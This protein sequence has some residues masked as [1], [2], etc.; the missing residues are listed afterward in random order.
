MSL[1]EYSPVGFAVE[2]F[3]QRYTIHPKEVFSNACSRVGGHIASAEQN[4]KREK[5]AERF[6]KIL[7]TNRFSPGGRIWRGCGRPKGQLLNCFV[8]PAEDSREGWGDLLKNT[9]IIS[10]LGGGIGINFSHVRPRG[11]EIKGTGG[12]A[13]GAVSLMEITNAVGDV[14]REGGGRRTALMFG[15]MY[16]HPDLKEF[17]DKKLDHDEINNANISVMIDNNFLDLVESNGDVVF[18]WQGQQKGKM[19][20]HKIWKTIV[21]NAWKCGDPGVLNYGLANEMNTISYLSNLDCTNPCG[22]QFLEPYG[23]CCLGSL[24]LSTHIIDGEMDW[25]LLGD[26][27]TLAVRFLDN[28]ISINHYPIKEVE[29]QCQNVRRIG[30]GVMG[31]HDMLLRMGLKYDQPKS[32][33]FIDK[34][35]GF[36]KKKSYE[37]SIFLAV[38]KGQFPGLDREAHIKTGFCKTL[39][40]GLRAK[41]LEYGIRNCTINTI[42]PTGTTSIVA[43]VSSGIEPMFSYAYK[44]S[45]VDNVQDAEGKGWKGKKKRTTVVIHPLFQEFIND[46]KSVKH[47]QSAHE[48]LPEFHLELQCICQRHVDNAITKTINV[49]SDITVNELSDVM[50][51]YARVLKGIT[52]YRDGSKGEAPLI[53]LSMKDATDCAQKNKGIVAAKGKECE[54]DQCEM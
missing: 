32:L 15:L 5:Y 13:T 37:S 49:P 2:I 1:P 53:P 28:V 51:K 42:P 22:E 12:I 20:A 46:G 30:L 41:I 48:I 16:N 4:G 7:L 25:E 33:E 26:T 8:I 43:A 39:S 10:G 14:I 27:I 44:R 36:I 17:I 19:K 18:E 50:L 24:V 3:S 45:W 52:I 21:E 9:V 6:T 38:E 23:S 34:L 47:F 11:T 54:G 40:K 29:Q 35:F 31:L